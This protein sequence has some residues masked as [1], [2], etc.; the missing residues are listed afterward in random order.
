MLLLG[1]TMNA[2]KSS[3]RCFYYVKLCLFVFVLNLR[4]FRVFANFVIFRREFAHFNF[5]SDNV[6]M[7]LQIFILSVYR[8]YKIYCQCEG[9]YTWCISFA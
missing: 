4:K 3:R 7:L 5:V 2:I 1:W 6:Q 8:F 9:H